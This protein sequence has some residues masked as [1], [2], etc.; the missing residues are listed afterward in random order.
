MTA[1]D[2]RLL[3]T[4]DLRLE[5]SG[6]QASVTA[7]GSHVTVRADSPVTLWSE[8]NRAALPS[9]V[10]RVSGPRA[11]GRAAEL[12]REHGLDVQIEGPQGV[13]VRLGTG[14]HSALGRSVT[15]SSAVQL[16]SV[17]SLRPIA[18]AAVAQAFSM[19]RV[20][21]VAVAAG[22]SVA[23]AVRRRARD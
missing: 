23:V 4:A 2:R 20:I 11:V 7:S 22:I 10:G 19:R 6:A 14:V 13:L 17:R 21:G 5:V 18:S 1:A 12:L 8:L 9:S 16:V 3:I 15:G